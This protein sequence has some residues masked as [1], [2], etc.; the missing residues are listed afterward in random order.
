LMLSG[1]KEENIFSCYIYDCCLLLVGKFWLKIDKFMSNLMN[2]GQ[3]CLLCS[4]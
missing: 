1:G 2:F 3:I 4:T